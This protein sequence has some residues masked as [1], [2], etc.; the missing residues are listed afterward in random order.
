MI[1]DL[2]SGST[3]RNNSR[4]LHS[5]EEST[6]RT[7]DLGAGFIPNGI[8]NDSVGFELLAGKDGSLAL[9]VTRL[10]SR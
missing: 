6:W 4:K 7:A 2:V 10:R 8:R 9:T 1:L 5:R 3:R